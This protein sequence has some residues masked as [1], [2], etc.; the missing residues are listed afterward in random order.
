[1]NEKWNRM[2]AKE[3]KNEAERDRQIK[4]NREKERDVL[5]FQLTH[6]C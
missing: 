5:L 1:M 4:I 3:R 6:V 2:R